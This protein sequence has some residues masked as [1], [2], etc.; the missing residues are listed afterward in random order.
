M[1][2]YYYDD[3][4]PIYIST[5]ERRRKAEREASKL[6]GA[7]PVVISGTQI[8]K[9]FWSGT[10]ITRIGFRV[11]VLTCAAVASLTFKFHPAW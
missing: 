5:A 3:E 10:A 1:A 11:G 7:S 2:R 8:A 4:F 6:K 9:T